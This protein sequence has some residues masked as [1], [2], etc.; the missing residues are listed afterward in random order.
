[1][2]MSTRLN[3]CVVCRAPMPDDDPHQSCAKCR[4]KQRT[5]QHRRRVTTHPQTMRGT[6]LCPHCKTAPKVPGQAYCRPCQSA[7]VKEFRRDHPDW[8]QGVLAKQREARATKRLA[9]QGRAKALAAQGNMQP[10]KKIRPPKPKPTKPKSE[11]PKPFQGK[12]PRKKNVQPP[13]DT[14]RERLAWRE[15]PSEVEEGTMIRV[16]SVP[17]DT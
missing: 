5:Y 14:W 12:P 9:L 11:L 16:I 15:L 8:W 13:D 7:I 10:P 3:V 4:E 2:T 6:G 17:I 1:M